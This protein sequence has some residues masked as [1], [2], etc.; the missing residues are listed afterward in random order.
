MSR[1]ARI[2]RSFGD[3]EHEYRIGIGQAEELD[4]LFKMGLVPLYAACADVRVPVVREVLRLARIGAGCG[5]DE[6]LAWVKRNVVDGSLVAAA[7]VAGDALRVALEAPEEDPPGESNGEGG[8]N[9]NPSPTA[10]SASQPSTSAPASL[11]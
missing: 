3:G 6:A 9:P 10:A 4:E 11:V 2:R 7:A 1:D 5:R 8:A